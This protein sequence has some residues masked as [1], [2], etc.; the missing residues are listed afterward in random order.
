MLPVRVLLVDDSPEFLRAASLFLSADP[1]VA[2]VGTARSG[3]DALYQ[4]E[5]VHPDLV[6]MDLAM[7]GMGGLEATRRIK[8]RPGAPGV[9][10]ITLL[11]NPEYRAAAKSVGADGFVAKSAF[12]TQLLSTIQSLFPAHCGQAEIKA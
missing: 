9:V 12:A 5:K 8:A 2:I 11:D 6:L 10:I 4:V 1:E 7:P 3:Q